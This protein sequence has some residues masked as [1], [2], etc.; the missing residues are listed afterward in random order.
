MLLGA[1]PH[2]TISF[3][4]FAVCDNYNGC[5]E[6]NAPFFR[7]KYLFKIHENN[8]YSSEKVFLQTP[9]F[10]KV[11]VHLYSLA[12]TRNKCVYVLSVPF[13]ALL[14]FLSGSK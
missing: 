14:L 4:L 12:P 9:I 8:A 11:S 6:S 3:V 5:P 2:I 1:M 7:G 13:L 10:H